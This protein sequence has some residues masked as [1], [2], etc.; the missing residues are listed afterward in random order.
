MKTLLCTLMLV[1]SL[2]LV[3][4]TNQTSRM[5]YLD[6]VEELLDRWDDQ[7]D[8]LKETSNRQT[9]HRID[10]LELD[11]RDLRGEVARARES[12]PETWEEARVRI[13]DQFR[14]ISNRSQALLNPA[15][16]R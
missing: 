5:S 12:S 15:T 9:F 2:T 16:A 13:E 14:A 3:G 7:L 10:E 11:T 8:D 6:H 4:A 1:T